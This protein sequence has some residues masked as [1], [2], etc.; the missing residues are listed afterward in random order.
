LL[1]HPKGLAAWSPVGRVPKSNKV[2]FFSG[3]IEVASAEY[4]ALL[5]ASDFLITMDNEVNG[6]GLNLNHDL[7]L[8]NMSDNQYIN[9]NTILDAYSE[10]TFLYE[11]TSVFA[12]REFSSKIDRTFSFLTTSTI[13]DTETFDYVTGEGNNVDCKLG[14]DMWNGLRLDKSTNFDGHATLRYLDNN[15]KSAKWYLDKMQVGDGIYFMDD[16]K[17]VTIKSGGHWQSSDLGI[18]RN[19]TGESFPGHDHAQIQFKINASHAPKEVSYKYIVDTQDA[20]SAMGPASSL[21]APIEYNV[22]IWSDSSDPAS[23]DDGKIGIHKSTIWK[24]TLHSGEIW[25]LTY[26]SVVNNYSQYVG[27][28]LKNADGTEYIFSHDW[29][30]NKLYLA[31]IK[32]S[33]NILD[34]RELANMYATSFS[35]AGKD[36]YTYGSGPLYDRVTADMD[37]SPN[38][39]IDSSELQDEGR[40]LVA[41]GYIVEL[42]HQSNHNADVRSI[43]ETLDEAETKVYG[44]GRGFYPKYST[45]KLYSEYRPNS[46]AYNFGLSGNYRVVTYSGI[47]NTAPLYEQ[48]FPNRIIVS[49]PNIQSEFYNGYRNLSGINY[50]DYNSEL[51]QIIKVITH[52]NILFAIFEN[53]IAVITVDGRTLI[54]SEQDVYIDSAQILAPKAQVLTSKFGSQN[55]ES[56]VT[57]IITIYGVDLMKNKIWRI[58]GSRF[59]II[60]DFKI[61]DILLEYKNNL[62]AS[63]V[64]DFEYKYSTEERQE[65]LPANLGGLPKIYSSADEVKKVV[66]FSY[67]KLMDD[68]S[69]GILKNFGN[70][71]FTEVLNTWVART[72]FA[73]K[74][75][76][77]YNNSNITFEVNLAPSEGWLDLIK[78]NYCNFRGTQYTFEFEFIVNG[79]PSV[80]KILTNLQIISNKV[81]PDTITYTVTPDINNAVIRQ[82]Q[83]NPIEDAIVFEDKIKI[84]EDASSMNIGIFISNAYYKDGKY[85]IQVGKTNSFSRFDDKYRRIRDKYFKV[86]VKYTG[87]EYTYIYSILSLFTV[88]FD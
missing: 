63:S 55:P 3:D 44:N 77:K 65:V 68:K 2:A 11:G 64:D 75:Q 62:L 59:N 81:K 28:T 70:I 1:V 37:I 29:M 56:I 80:E 34:S 16:D 47:D 42:L 61:E 45:D 49:E 73:N 33:K 41:N 74:F 53:G 13:G 15:N 18:C 19:F 8:F 36:Y 66:H 52:N 76:F 82:N 12:H 35:Y 51:G 27:C 20:A 85:F 31:N 88:N 32:A 25:S 50:R 71:Q 39:E 38:E 48:N 5:D 10:F 30:G 7:R 72:V 54:N 17:L 4:A 69:E 46:K 22:Y 84:R 57:S 40:K 86:R 79:M 67:N 9:N 21:S 87:D 26:A 14:T 83:L 78:G 24:T 58:E 43:E 6:V 60:S 23:G